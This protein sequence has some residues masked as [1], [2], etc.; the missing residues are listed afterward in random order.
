MKK[1]AV[2]MIMLLAT[3]AIGEVEAGGSAVVEMGMCS[4]SAGWVF[5]GC[6]AVGPCPCTCSCRFYGQCRCICAN[7]AMANPVGD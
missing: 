2:L 1:F 7:A 4:C 3:L 6:S 5:G